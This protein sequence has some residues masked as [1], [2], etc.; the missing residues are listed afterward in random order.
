MS[1]LAQQ[2]PPISETGAGPILVGVTGAQENTEALRFAVAAARS[3]GQGI[4]LVHAV[5]PLMPPPPP[6]IVTF[7][8]N[9]AEVGSS[10]ATDVHRELEALLGGAQV[11][12]STSV[13][14][15]PPGATLAELSKKAS[16]VV[17]QHRDLSRLHRLVTGSTVTAVAAHAHCPVVSVPSRGFDRS[18]TGVVTAG[19]HQDAEPR[20]VLETA[21]AAASARR[22]SLRVLHAWHVPDG[23]SDALV[24]KP[25]W[26]RHSEGLIKAATADLQEKYPD[27]RLRVEARH[28][29]PADAL[30]QASA[31][32]DLLVVGRHGAPL[33]FP[34]RLGSIARAMIMHAACPVEIVPL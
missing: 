30:A 21:F 8:D 27:V 28:N 1:V 25:Q 24:E 23:Y 17:L 3:G 13:H 12:I 4:T 14:H 5:A 10:I 29:W 32:S 7:D 9:W 15:G 6:N 18:P 22:A 31:A 19:V 11:T 2:H 34:S 20:Q 16:M 26:S 33:G